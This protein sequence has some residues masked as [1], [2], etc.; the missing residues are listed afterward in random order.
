MLI[1]EVIKL[2]TCTVDENSTVKQ[3]IQNATDCKT[4][5]FYICVTWN[6]KY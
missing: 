1:L 3:G 6:S 4:V 5:D 2:L